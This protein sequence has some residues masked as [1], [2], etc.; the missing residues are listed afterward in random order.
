MALKKTIPVLLLS[1]LAITPCGCV[2]SKGGISAEKPPV[3]PPLGQYLPRALKI[4]SFTQLG[5]LEDRGFGVEAYAQ[6]IDAWGEP[7]KA[8]G[9]F[10]FELYEFRRF[11]HERKGKP[12]E[13]WDIHIGRPKENRSFWDHH[14]RSYRFMLGMKRTIAPGRKMVLKVTYA[15]PFVERLSTEAAIVSGR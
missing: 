15:D 9:N 11:H 1:A 7:T 5:N 6:A 13:T 12:V 4:H 8:F 14:T 2:R 10:R 3:P